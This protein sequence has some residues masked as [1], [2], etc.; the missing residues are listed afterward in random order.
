MT[1]KK[2]YL[3]TTFFML[4]FVFSPLF[5]D[6]RKNNQSP[7]SVLFEEHLVGNEIPLILFSSDGSKVLVSQH[8]DTEENKQLH[9]VYDTSTNDRRNIHSDVIPLF[10]GFTGGRLHLMKSIKISPDLTSLCVISRRMVRKPVVVLNAQIP[11]DESDIEYPAETN[12]QYTSHIEFAEAA[13]IDL[14]S[15]KKRD[16][17]Q[18]EARYNTDRA[19]YPIGYAPDG[20]YLCYD[21][22]KLMDVYHKLQLY[23]KTN[24][25]LLQTYPAEIAWGYKPVLCHDY[26]YS[27]DGKLIFIP[28]EKA[29]RE[30]NFSPRHYAL[31][32]SSETGSVVSVVI[33]DD[34]SLSYPLMGA[35]AN[36]D[37]W[38][39]CRLQNSTSFAAFSLDSS[40]VLIP[41]GDSQLE[42]FDVNAKRIVEIINTAQFF[43]N[44]K[45][46]IFGASFTNDS[47]I[48]MILSNL[49][50][51][52]P[53]IE[54]DNHLEYV[55]V[56][57][58]LLLHEITV[59]TNSL[60][61]F[62][63]RDRVSP[64]GRTIL[65]FDSFASEE[66]AETGQTKKTKSTRQLTFKDATTGEILAT[67]EVPAN[68]QMMP[69]VIS[70]D[71]SKMVGY[72]KEQLI[73]Y[74]ITGIINRP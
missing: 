73:I 39:N 20:N 4:C 69:V 12:L 38:G 25:K 55:I 6:D 36:M 1:F 29:G 28:M 16:F 74:D 35:R 49:S 48:R 51:N 24:G 66:D 15:G 42:L 23:D 44:Y 65:S 62:E 33:L 53:T 41:R 71:W 45:Y 3:V 34:I 30:H 11:L 40:K 26:L 67:Q 46:R 61:S 72:G 14:F 37:F 64:D 52:V 22:T 70:D 54:Y 50:C 8:S 5:G 19:V 27:P 47:K 43:Q 60:E 13:M 68:G 59:I 17:P 63:H 9:F 10:Y 21:K 58:D 31:I 18:R 7:I 56:E 57:Y 2:I 32:C